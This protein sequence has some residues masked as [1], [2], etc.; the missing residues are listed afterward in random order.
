MFDID[1]NSAYE[2]RF[3]LSLLT[4]NYGINDNKLCTR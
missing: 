1:I 2:F 3:I 4:K